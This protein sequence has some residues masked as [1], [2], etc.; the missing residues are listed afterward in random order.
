MRKYTFREHLIELKRRF[1]ILFGMFLVAFVLCYWV[2]DK[3]YRIILSPLIEIIGDGGRKIIYTSLTEAFFSYIK[4]SAFAAFILVFPVCCY[5]VY[6][7]IKPGLHK[8]ERKMVASVLSLSPLLFYFGSFFMFYWVMPN[9]WLFFISYEKVDVGLPLVLEARIS[10][11]LSLVIQLTL[12]FGISFQLPIIMIILSSLGLVSSESLKR[13]RRVAIVIIFIVAA[14]LTPPD[15]FSQIALAI[16]LLL[17]YE[18]SILL[19]KL[20]EKK[21]V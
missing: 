3:I 16:P 21:R 14:I 10:E 11:Y 1:L 2:S 18:F 6:A 13:K 17:L 19:C 12:A 9:A 15:V 8:E 20:L 7:F 5:Q 4:L